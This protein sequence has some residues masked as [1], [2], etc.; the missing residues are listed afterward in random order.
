MK[1]R[2]LSE[3]ADK[4]SYRVPSSSEIGLYHGVDRLHTT[5]NTYIY[6]CDCIGWMTRGHKIPNFECRHIKSVR[7]FE[8]KETNGK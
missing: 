7:D 8:L 5:A 2:K 1:V 3:T 4:T 6:R